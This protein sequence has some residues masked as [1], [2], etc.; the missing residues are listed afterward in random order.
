[1][2]IKREKKISTII[3][4]CPSSSE[5]SFCSEDLHLGKEGRYKKLKAGKNLDLNHFRDDISQLLFD[6]TYLVSRQ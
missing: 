1:M 2:E 4:R 3:S 5:D 6:I